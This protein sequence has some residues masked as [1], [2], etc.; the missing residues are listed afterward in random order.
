MPCYCCVCS[1]LVNIHPRLME[2]TEPH[3]VHLGCFLDV[4]GQLFVYLMGKCIWCQ[5]RCRI[6]LG[7]SMLGRVCLSAHCLSKFI[8]D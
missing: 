7:A 8:P 6:S 5:L 2:D 4:L 1:L 3:G